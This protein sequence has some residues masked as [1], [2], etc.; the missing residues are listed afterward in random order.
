L[1]LSVN[2][3]TQYTTFS[4]LFAQI[5]SQ[6]FQLQTR[7]N[8]NLTNSADGPSTTLIVIAAVTFV[9]ALFLMATLW[10]REK[11]DSIHSRQRQF[12]RVDGLFFRIQGALLD[13]DEADRYLSGQLS[14]PALLQ[15]LLMMKTESLTLV[16]LSVGGC[17]F[18][19]PYALKKGS[20]LLLQLGSL[21]DFPEENLIVACRVIWSRRDKGSHGGM[22]SAGCKFVFPQGVRVPDDALKTYITFLMDEPVG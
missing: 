7:T 1:E 21:P 2:F 6:S 4:P 15:G 8:M 18:I 12:G 14:N 3:L 9:L 17:A 20:V 10:P 11:S 22:D 13:N 5:G 19:T 16:S